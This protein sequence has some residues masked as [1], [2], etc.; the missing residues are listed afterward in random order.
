VCGISLSDNVIELIFHLF[1]ANQDGNLCSDEF[2]RVMHRRE[3][4]MAQ[5]TKSGIKNAFRVLGARVWNWT[6]KNGTPVICSLD[7]WD[8][9]LSDLM[10]N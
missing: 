5:L 8:F 3:R 7:D 1:D 4:E 6:A 10:R 9:G 2:L